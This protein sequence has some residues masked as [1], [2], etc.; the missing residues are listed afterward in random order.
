MTTILAIT[1]LSLIITWVWAYKVDKALRSE[2]VSNK[3]FIDYRR[4]VENE[5]SLINRC[6]QDM[7]KSLLK[8][9]STAYSALVQVLPTS[10][11]KTK[12]DITVGK[13]YKLKADGQGRIMYVESKENT[14]TSLFQESNTSIF[15]DY[16]HRILGTQKQITTV[17]QSGKRQ[18]ISL[19]AFFN[20]IVTEA[21][22]N[23]RL[24]QIKEAIEEAEKEIEISELTFSNEIKQ[25]K[26]E[27]LEKELEIL[28]KE[29]QKLK[30]KKR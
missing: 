7:E 24:N 26:I 28:A 1:G 3:E 4:F 11:P 15:A 19:D 16:S 10:Y 6:I 9:S 5:M 14:S 2:T 30:S 27:K 25:E 12:S 17:T 23:K 20:M 18:E 22:Q 13:V 8:T 29:N 21:E